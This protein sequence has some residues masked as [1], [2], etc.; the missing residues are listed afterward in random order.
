MTRSATKR[1]GLY[2]SALITS[3]AIAQAYFIDLSA[4]PALAQNA[5]A[6]VTTSTTKVVS[7]ITVPE[8]FQVELLHETDKDDEGSWVSLCAAPDGTLYAS[9]QYMDYKSA[10][11][12]D[13]KRR[14]LYNIK[15]APVGDPNGQTVIT[16]QPID[17]NGAQGLCYAFGALYVME[18]GVGVQRVTDSNGDG[19]LDS[20]ELLV[21]VAGGGEH[22]TH[23]IV[24]SPDGKGLLIIGGNMTPMAKHN[25]SLPV[26][27]WDEDQLLPRERDANGHA[28]N[29]MAPG[30]WIGRMDP[31]GK[32]VTIICNG[33]RN[34]YDIAVAPNGEI[35]TYDSDMEWDL[36]APWYRPTRV[37][38]VT[39]G[40]EFGWRNGSGKWPAY[41]E[42]S[43]SSVVDIGP[44]S[45]VGVT[46]GTGAKFPTKCQEA[47]YILDWT[48]G[49]IYSV[50]IA[51][52]GSTY[53]GKLK[54]FLYAKALPLTDVAIA[55]DGAMY[56][57]I[58]GRR[59]P[60]ALYRVTYT[61]SADTTPPATR[62][63][64]ELAQLRH[65]L[66]TLHTAGVPASKLPFIWENL[67][68]SDRRVRFAARVALEHM[69]P[70]AYASRAN[71]EDDALTRVAAGL[72]LAR[73]K[74]AAAL[75]VL[76]GAKP[77]AQDTVT[78]LAWMRALGVAFARGATVTEDQ[79]KAVLETLAALDANE[80][81][82]VK[83]EIVRLRV[84]LQD[85]AVIGYALDLIKGMKTEA[86]FWLYLAEK[87]DRYGA[88]IKDMIKN[89]PPSNQLGIAFM[90]RNTSKGWSPTQR[91]DYFSWLNV[92]SQGGGG[93]SYA[94][95][96]KKI[97][98]QAIAT[99]TEDEKASLGPL[100]VEPPKNLPP[101]VQPEGPGRK[102]AVK[103]ASALVDGQLEN[104]DYDKGV[105][106]FQ[107][108]TC[109]QCHRVGNLGGQI[110]PDLTP[111][112]GKFTIEALM[113]AIID[114]SK[115]I[116]DQFAMH[117]V[118]TKDARTIVGYIVDESEKAVKIKP[119]PL[120]DK[121]V[122]IPVDQ[123]VSNKLSQVSTMPVGLIN[124]LSA[125][126]LRDLTAFILS[127]GDRNS[128]MFK[129]AEEKKA[130]EAAPEKPAG[131]N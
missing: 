64:N 39:S 91:Q 30:G 129:Q 125:T 42:D 118:V 90:L 14:T 38:H 15:P 34:A 100:L 99:L 4:P 41:F 2:I 70:E 107:A 53:S 68:H 6:K 7:E 110:G 9:A 105:G 80:D 45:P 96:L 131:C 18:T 111:A 54:P 51:E 22:G 33:F 97:R 16:P 10:D 119:N 48:Y 94:G 20:K 36:G 12:K 106:L 109:S 62:P 73:H 46:F 71:S 32:N 23:A 27:M 95:Y 108:V 101:I 19:L 52:D 121:T 130:E 61:G 103:M 58:G 78:S 116:S 128:K 93:N 84:Y 69:D 47:I 89:P 124:P 66:E 31:D 8:G 85:P 11:K 113:E 17:L 102:W 92:A 5:Q 82:F 112:A 57:T 87:N 55:K 60:S 28:A 29:V 88:A 98:E 104:R 65:E 1:T 115:E 43:V 126:E 3:L 40:A 79:K 123:I 81:Q 127:G 72:S 37:C 13:A 122:E 76:L 35:F 26:E 21:K 50:D 83:T 74:H 25:K 44:G 56:F 117:E 67:G 49:T 86:P 24:I 75:P 114:P 63:L 59:T 77:K 120:E